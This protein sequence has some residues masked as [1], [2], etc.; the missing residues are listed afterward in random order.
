MNLHESTHPGWGDEADYFCQR[1]QEDGRTELKVPEVVQS[2]REKNATWSASTPVA[3][4]MET[5]DTLHRKSQMPQVTSQPGSSQMRL[6]LQKPLIYEG[7]Q[8]FPPT[9]PLDSSV[10]QI[11]MHVE[12]V[13]YNPCTQ[14]SKL[15]TIQQS[16]SD[17][18]MVTAPESPEK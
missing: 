11:S 2:Q 7:I 8:S 4:P 17:E 9:P 16:G 14:S 10:I 12:P 6:G 1:D 15:I 13:S 5:H 3:E 18:D